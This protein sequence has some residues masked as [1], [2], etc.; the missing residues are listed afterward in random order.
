[1]EDIEIR[2]SSRRRRTVTARREGGRTVVLMPAG[3]SAAQ[4]QQHVD[5]LLARLERRER[6]RRPSDDDLMERARRLSD[7]YLDGQAEPASIR[8]VTNQES[9]W[10]SCSVGDRSIRLSHRL[11]GLPDWVVDSVIVH[12]LAHL[13][14]PHHGPAFWA[15]AGRYPRME[16]ARGFLEGVEHPR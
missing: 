11:Q 8:W 7:R 4:E 6:G 13:V 14:E 2:R 5:T 16:R 15:L 12:E 3:L 9:R 1:M 10:G